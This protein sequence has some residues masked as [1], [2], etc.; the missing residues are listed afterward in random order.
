MIKR[1]GIYVAIAVAWGI[2]Y[3]AKQLFG[4]SDV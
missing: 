3:A 2:A 4:L 1:F